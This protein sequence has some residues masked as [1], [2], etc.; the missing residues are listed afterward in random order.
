M[1]NLLLLR[2]AHTERTARSDM[3]RVLTGDGRAEV[4][5]FGKILNSRG[6]DWDLLVCSPAARAVETAELLARGIEYPESAIINERLLYYA[7]AEEIAAFI[8]HLDDGLES[9]IIIGHNPVLLELV[10]ML[11]VKTVS[12]LKPCHA[13]KFRFGVDTWEDIA[14]GNCVNMFYLS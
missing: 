8:R 6:I 14:P 3:Q 12:V 2:H 11:G 10:N 1:K 4:D 5:V 9:V 7:G 13:V